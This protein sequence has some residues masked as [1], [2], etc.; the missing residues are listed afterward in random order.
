[1]TAVTCP[2]CN[3]T[4]A[5]PQGLASH[6][7]SMHPDVARAAGATAG[8]TGAPPDAPGAPPAH[9][10][11][12]EEP[13]SPRRSSQYTEV[14]ALIPELRRNPGRWARLYTWSN[15]TG[16]NGLQQ[17]LRKDAT[18]ADCEFIGRITATGS[19]LYGRCTG[20]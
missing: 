19:A 17:R 7:R 15:K 8:A 14:L 11:V 16:A 13:P 1:M 3:R 5:G 9:G 4:C 18:V 2:H 20:E 12:W 10:L 6:I